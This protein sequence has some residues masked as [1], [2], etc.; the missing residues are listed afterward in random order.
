[1]VTL[2]ETF[3]RVGGGEYH[4]P[5]E[6]QTKGIVLVFISHECPNSSNYAPTLIDLHQQ[7]QSRGVDL[8]LVYAETDITADEAAQ[9][10]KEF[11]YTCPAILDNQL[12]LARKYGVTT[13]PEAVLLSPARKMVYRG[14]IDNRYPALG[15]RVIDPTQHDL[16]DAVESLLA[17]QQIARSTTQAIGCPIQELGIGGPLCQPPAN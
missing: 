15:K 14:R 6:Q 3:A 1:M 10:A 8:C 7:F 5:A 12:A 4:L 2:P 13:T 17:G 9:N 11:G 16:R